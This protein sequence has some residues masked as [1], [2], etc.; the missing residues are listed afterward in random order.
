MCSFRDGAKGRIQVHSVELWQAGVLVAGEIGVSVGTC[1]CSYSGFK[2]TDSSGTAQCLALAKYLNVLG[3]QL[4]DLG[5]GLP[6]KY[7]FG[8]ANVPRL[9]FMA[10]VRKIREEPTPHLT[11]TPIPCL[12]LFPPAGQ[13]VVLQRDGPEAAPIMVP[14]KP[15]PQRDPNSKKSRK[16]AAKK[17]R[18]AEYKAA[19]AKARGEA[20][21]APEV[22]T[23]GE[24]PLSDNVVV[25]ESAAVMEEMQAP[26]DQ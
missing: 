24:A 16:H 11:T 19:R 14:T 3:F 13:P 12:Q 15:L 25:S 18:I 6:Y 26:T 23:E 5:M 22:Q 20:A 21:K 10:K 7:K 1:Y 4:W 9:L 17:A 8:A 2:S